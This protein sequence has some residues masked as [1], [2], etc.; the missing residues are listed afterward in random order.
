MST[1]TEKAAT[2]SALIRLQ[3]RLTRRLEQAVGELVGPVS[4]ELRAYER[5][6]LREFR[7]YQAT[8]DLDEIL[9]QTQLARLVLCGDFHS[10]PESQRTAL[11][12]ESQRTALALLQRLASGSRRWVLCLEM[13]RQAD[14]THLDRFQSGA[15]S[16]QT[17][18]KAVDFRRSWGFDWTAIRPLVHFARDHG[19]RL[20]GLNTGP[21]A[22]LSSRDDSMAKL[23]SRQILDNPQQGVFVLVGDHHLA[24]PHLPAAVRR[25]LPPACSPG[26]ILRI[27]QNNEAVFW[28]LANR[29]LELRTGAVRLAEHAYCVLS[30]TP[31]TKWESYLNWLENGDQPTGRTPAGEH[32]EPGYQTDQLVDL[33]ATVA[34]FLGL[35]RL[36]L[37]GFSAYSRDRQSYSSE[38]LHRCPELRSYLPAILASDVHVLPELELIYLGNSDIDHLAEAAAEYV[39]LKASGCPLSRDWEGTSAFAQRALRKALAFAGSMLVNPKRRHDLHTTGWATDPPAARALALRYA[40]SLLQALAAPQ[41]NAQDRKLLD[42]A[43]GDDPR[44]GLGISTA[45]G[46]ALGARLFGDYTGGGIDRKQLRRLYRQRAVGPEAWLTLRRLARGRE[47]RLPTS[48]AP[49]GQRAIEPE[50]VSPR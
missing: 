26:A 29:G 22:R 48:P 7:D 11:A 2:P 17:F 39:H 50:A 24:G 5:R 16:E 28:K 20:L 3:R 23:L 36:C 35:R 12:P 37:D 21:A 33:A 49:A 14:Q 40:R 34:R 19:V 44:L 27:Q 18:L 6:F 42:A 10:Y 30:G 32:D 43:A 41:L 38:L 45:L 4:P 46:R 9:H 8:A 25:R 15:I 31:W 47:G 1:T 13:I